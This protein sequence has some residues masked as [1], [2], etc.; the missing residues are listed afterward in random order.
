MDKFVIRYYE[1][2]RYTVDQMKVFVTANW[3]TEKQFE[4]VTGVSFGK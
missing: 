3:I 4:E 2:G 1:Q